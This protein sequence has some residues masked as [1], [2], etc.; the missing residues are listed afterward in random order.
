MS[1]MVN[2]SRASEQI[3]APFSVVILQGTVSLKLDTAFLISS[4][5]E[6]GRKQTDS[7]KIDDL[8]V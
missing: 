4:S 6:F 2:S 3:G 5:R 7:E 1:F 8:T